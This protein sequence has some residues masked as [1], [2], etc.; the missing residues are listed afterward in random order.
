MTVRRAHAE[1]VANGESGHTVSLRTHVRGVESR[2]APSEATPRTDRGVR[3]RYG[4]A[5]EN[6]LTPLTVTSPGFVSPCQA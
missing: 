2:S 4:L 5:T 3:G 1:L 6:P